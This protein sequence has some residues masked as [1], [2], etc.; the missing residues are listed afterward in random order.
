VKEVIKSMNAALAKLPWWKKI[1]LV[2]SYPLVV[3]IVWLTWR[4]Q[5]AEKEDKPNETEN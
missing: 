4:N 5:L 2:V 3:P 1:L